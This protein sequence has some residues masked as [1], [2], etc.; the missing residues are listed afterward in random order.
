LSF[1]PIDQYQFVPNPLGSWIERDLA[2]KYSSSHQSLYSA[3]ET[4]LL[5]ILSNISCSL[6]G[7]GMVVTP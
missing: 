1:Y 2:L 6:G 4:A 3:A 5:A 7:N